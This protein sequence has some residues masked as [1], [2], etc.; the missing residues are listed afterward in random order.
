MIFR[1]SRKVRKFLSQPRC[2]KEW[3]HFNDKISLSFRVCIYLIGL[4]I[5]LETDSNTS[6]L[7]KNTS[8]LK[9]VTCGYTV[10]AE[11]IFLVLGEVIYSSRV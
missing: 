5:S 2:Q 11:R 6:A 4:T 8:L 9:T 3:F 10:V 1:L 7:F